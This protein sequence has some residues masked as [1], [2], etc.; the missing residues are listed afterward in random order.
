M[1]GIILCSIAVMLSV[2]C[3]PPEQMISRALTVREIENSRRVP[4]RAVLTSDGNLL[5]QGAPA[6][7]RLL[8]EN[9][10]IE[11]EEIVLR[12]TIEFSLRESDTNNDLTKQTRPIERAYLWSPYSL[13]KIYDQKTSTCQD[14]LTPNRYNA[15]GD[16]KAN[17]A[18]IILS[19]GERR[20]LDVD[21]NKICWNHVMLSDYPR[22]SLF[23]V[24]ERQPEFKA[25]K[26]KVSFSAGVVS[27]SRV[28][29]GLQTMF[30]SNEIDINVK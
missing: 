12:A 2:S 17:D 25:K 9:V 5:E 30:E 10:D 19:K 3:V 13:A 15:T 1:K 6:V 29:K 26:Y 21:L 11:H 16:I 22:W 7:V 14:D 8:I 27:E 20:E 28:Y 23:S 4:I 24:L 18:T